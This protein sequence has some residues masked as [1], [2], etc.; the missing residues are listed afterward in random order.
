MVKSHKAVNLADLGLL[1]SVTQL[2]AGW[3]SIGAFWAQAA[4]NAEIPRSGK[5]T[6]I[7]R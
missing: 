6:G 5:E 3:G 2:D 7:A 4:A 1:E